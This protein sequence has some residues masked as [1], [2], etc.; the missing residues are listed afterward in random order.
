MERERSVDCHRIESQ[1]E[2]SV[3]LSPCRQFC[4]VQELSLLQDGAGQRSKSTRAA[5]GAVRWPDINFTFL[6]DA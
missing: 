1:R 2:H 6:A 3:E 5:P 4:P